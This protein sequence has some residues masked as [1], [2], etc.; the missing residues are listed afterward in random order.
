MGH[1]AWSGLILLTQPG[2]RALTPA[3]AGDRARECCVLSVNVYICQIIMMENN[4]FGVG[5]DL[6][7]SLKSPFYPLLKHFE[8]FGHLRHMCLFCLQ[9]MRQEHNLT[10]FKTL[11]RTEMTRSGVAGTRWEE[12]YTMWPKHGQAWSLK[13]S[14]W[15]H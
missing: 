7:S 12:V 14:K 5:N 10:H 3:W 6:S 13:V 2:H 4:R 9:K 8:H 15:C 1:V 11:M